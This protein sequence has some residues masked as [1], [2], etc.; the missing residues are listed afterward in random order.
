[1]AMVNKTQKA[2]N[3]LTAKKK[4]PACRLC[5][6][7][8]TGASPKTP[9][10]VCKERYPEAKRCSSCGRI[11]PTR[12]R[13]S[14]GSSYCRTCDIRKTKLKIKRAK[15]K[16]GVEDEEEEPLPSAEENPADENL[17][18]DQPHLSGEDDPDCEDFF[19]IDGTK[20]KRV[21]PTCMEQHEGKRFLTLKLGKKIL[22]KIPLDSFE[23]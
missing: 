6:I 15:K 17:D 13:F 3:K 9:C 21:L 2:K 4:L 5:G 10:D 22:A 20:R 16:T 1:M 23:K 12:N 11:F 19:P 7:E 18:S 8:R 14:N